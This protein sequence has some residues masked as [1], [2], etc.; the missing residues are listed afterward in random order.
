M[1]RRER[2]IHVFNFERVIGDSETHSGLDTRR[3]KLLR[4]VLLFKNDTLIAEARRRELSSY[5]DERL[6]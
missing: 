6:R 1:A 2:N 4:L 3:V 5:V